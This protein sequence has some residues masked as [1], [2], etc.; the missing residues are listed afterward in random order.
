MALVHNAAGGV[1]RWSLLQARADSGAKEGSRTSYLARG[2]IL[3]RVRVLKSGPGRLVG[4][5]PKVLCCANLGVGITLRRGD[6][7][8]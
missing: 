2:H 7:D 6:C 3:V 8:H 4:Q 5:R 1:D